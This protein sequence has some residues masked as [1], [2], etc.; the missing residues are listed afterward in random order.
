[1]KY[2]IVRSY[3]NHPSELV[4]RGLTLDEAQTH[5]GNRDTSSST[6]TTPEGRARTE[7]KGFWFDG[8]DVDEKT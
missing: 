5:C 7:T 6:C 8:Y 4:K 2:K 1:M 3:L